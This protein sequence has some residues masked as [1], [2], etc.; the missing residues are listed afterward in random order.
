M[1]IKINISYSFYRRDFIM[2]SRH[3][4][5][6]LLTGLIILLIGVF[7]VTPTIFLNTNQSGSFNADLST[8]PA[9]PDLLNVGIPI[10]GQN[11]AATTSYYYKT[12]GTALSSRYSVIWVCPPSNRDCNL[13][14]S[15][16]NFTTF[17]RNSTRAGIGLVE[18]VV[19]RP[20]TSQNLYARVRNT[21]S[22]ATGVSIEWEDSSESLTTSTWRSKSLSTA[23]A[24]EVYGVSMKKTSNYTI[25][26]VVP[27]GTNFD[28]Y[29]YSLEP[30]TAANISG[31][32]RRSINGGSS[33]EAIRG[34]VPSANGL[35]AVLVVRVSGTGAYNLTLAATPIGG[36]STLNLWLFPVIEIPVFFGVV[37]GVMGIIYLHRHQKNRIRV[38]T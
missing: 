14:F 36:G 22:S 8:N 26:L 18:W 20:S 32:I 1:I 33:A 5:F 13:Y 6:F 2:K 27:G 35:F 17:M 21:G 29:L 15:N 10:T 16:N 19:F 30:G 3:S 24:I 37:F 4:L 12:N 11:Y 25:N 23:N 34:F 38:R 31:F 9:N 7:T 28:L